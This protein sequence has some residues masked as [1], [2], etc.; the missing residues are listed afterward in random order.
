[1]RPPP[2]GLSSA[3]NGAAIDEMVGLISTICA[4]IG[5]AIATQPATIIKSGRRQEAILPLQDRHLPMNCARGAAEGSN[6]RRERQ[7][8]KTPG[9]RRWVIKFPNRQ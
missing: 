9:V 2:L 5:N 4:R 6:Y 3:G 8:N 1:M 7:S